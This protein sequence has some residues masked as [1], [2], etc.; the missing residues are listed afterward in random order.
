[1]KAIELIEY[2]EEI[3]P[4]K[5]AC[6][7]DNVG[8]LAGRRDKEVKKVYVALDATDEVV[9][10]A[11]M[12]KCD[13]LLTHHPLLFRSVKRITDEDF[14]GRRLLTLLGN[15][16]S[17]YAMHTSFD[18]A[19]DGMADMASLL[20]GLQCGVPMEVMSDELETPWGIGKTGNLATPCTLRELCEM[21]KERFQVSHVS[22]YPARGMESSVKRVAICPGSGRSMLDSAKAT[23][24]EVLITGDIGHHEGIDAQAMGI[25]VIDAGHFGLEKIFIPIMAERLHEKFPELEVFT[26]APTQPCKVL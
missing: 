9:A 3:V 15:D 1:M 23:Q 18:A 13:F 14:I 24:A 17:Y 26:A 2:L 19:P 10:D 25:S 16:I 20:L 5:C 7:W 6:D 22:V 4:V 12:K 11:A 21:V 8:L